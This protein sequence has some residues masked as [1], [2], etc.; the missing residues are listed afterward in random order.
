M[1][2]KSIKQML[3]EIN[4][5]VEEIKA[6][7]ITIKINRE[8]FDFGDKGRLA[9]EIIPAINKAIAQPEVKDPDLIEYQKYIFDKETF[10]QDILPQINKSLGDSNEVRI[11]NKI[12][13]HLQEIERLFKELNSD[14]TFMITVESAKAT[15][16]GQSDLV[17]LVSFTKNIDVK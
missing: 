1:R 10:I 11:I 15:F 2:R 12:N 5:K 4:S 9:R 7:K 3:D 6:G 13:T 8:P 16:N 14:H 17:V